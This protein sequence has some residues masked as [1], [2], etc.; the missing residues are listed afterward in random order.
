MVTDLVSLPF[1]IYNASTRTKDMNNN[2]NHAR[3][4]ERICSERQRISG[5]LF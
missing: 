5:K 3:G 4:F 2:K 1:Y